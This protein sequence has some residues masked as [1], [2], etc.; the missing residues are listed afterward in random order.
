MT[1]GLVAVTA[2][3]VLLVVSLGLFMTLLDS[4]R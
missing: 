2:G 1:A 4:T 3:M